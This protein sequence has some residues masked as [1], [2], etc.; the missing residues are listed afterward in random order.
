MTWSFSVHDGS[1]VRRIA[2]ADALRLLARE[3]GDPLVGLEV[4]L[5]PRALALRVDQ[6]EGVRTEAVHVAQRSRDAA[7]AEEPGELVRRF[8][9][10]REEVPDVVGLLAVAERV[11]LLRVDE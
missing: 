4:E 9:R 6:H 5:D 3:A 8:R 10:V 2:A 1:L 11:V 7:I